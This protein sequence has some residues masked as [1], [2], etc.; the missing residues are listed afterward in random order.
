MFYLYWLF[1]VK[2]INYIS[3]FIIYFWSLFNIDCNMITWLLCEATE[4][5]K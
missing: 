1:G 4:D 2:H 5:N 3:E